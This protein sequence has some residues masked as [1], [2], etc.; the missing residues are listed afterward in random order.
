M[1]SGL[2][3]DSFTQIPVNYSLRG[4]SVLFVYM[5]FSDK[6]RQRHKIYMKWKIVYRTFGTP[7]EKTDLKWIYCLTLSYT[8]M[9]AFFLILLILSRI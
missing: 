8:C 4:P 1:L 9:H 5:M 3:P 6:I 2:S 7:K